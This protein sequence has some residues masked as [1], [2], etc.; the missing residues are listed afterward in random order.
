MRPCNLQQQCH[1][2]DLVSKGLISVVGHKT[3][4][5]CITKNTN[6]QKI[7]FKIQGL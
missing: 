6:G 1:L 5:L 7:S 4:V 3:V 2:V